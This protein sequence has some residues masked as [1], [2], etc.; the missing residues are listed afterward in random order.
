MFC[1]RYLIVLTDKIVTFAS[2]ALKFTFLL[3]GYLGKLKVTLQD[4]EPHGHGYKVKDKCIGHK[5]PTMPF[6]DDGTEEFVDAHSEII[7]L[8]YR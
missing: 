4:A 8:G 1:N 6:R 2:R 5:R 7:I 3:Y